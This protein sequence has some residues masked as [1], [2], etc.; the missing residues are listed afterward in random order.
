MLSLVS[1]LHVQHTFSFAGYQDSRFSNFHCLRVINEDRVIGG[2]GFGT[3]PHANYE[4][5]SYVVGGALSHRDSM[6]NKEIIARGD[7][8]V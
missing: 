6:G 7:I 2:E 5:F 3:H 8:Q 4:I 1:V